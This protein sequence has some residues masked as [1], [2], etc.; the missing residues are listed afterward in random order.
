MTLPEGTP[1]V[2]FGDDW[3]RNVSTMQHV[4]RHVLARHP[5]VWV[6]AIGHRVPTLQQKDLRR[7]LEKAGRLLGRGTLL[8]TG[9]AAP[10]TPS[11]QVLIEPMV[12]PWHHLGIVHRY[13]T[14]WLRA[15]V[16]RGLGR[17]GASEPPVLVTGTPP[18]VGVVGTLG[19]QASI[20]YCMDDFL[21]HPH[22]TGWMIRP[23]EARLLDRVD[24][25]V[26]T[27]RAL[28]ESKTPASGRSYYLPQGVN[29]EHF[30]AP[31][32]M[33]DELRRLPRPI[34]GFAGGISAFL[35][36]A[37]VRDV[38]A[39]VTTGSIVL[40]GPSY[41]PLE[42]A[43]ASMPNVHV[44]GPR[45]YADLPAYVQAFDVGLI[46]YRVDP[47]TDTIDP[48][49]LLEYLAAGI[50]VVTTALS[51][52][53]KYAEVIRIA[54]PAHRFADLVLQ[55]I[56]DDRSAARKQAQAL[57]ASHS[58]AHRAEE[59]LAIVEATI[60]SRRRMTGAPSALVHA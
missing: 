47:T 44:L 54:D 21:N 49:K 26:A 33:P 16:R 43:L 46:P 13:N 48:L 37:L 27:A 36:Q 34:I 32:P 58:W 4:F 8:T 23:L 55:A 20:Y 14:S 3:G 25:V 39:R 60:A 6:N 42:N 18:S 57:A 10:G 15:A 2:V 24:A 22:A 5:V 19:E 29:Y 7:W 17:L 40:V 11:P 9:M 51:E 28:S 53:R 50:P 31:R 41:H 12:L 59:F 1:F 30:A 56:S 45:S 52:A 35:D 38:A